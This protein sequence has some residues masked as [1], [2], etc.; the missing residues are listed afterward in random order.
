MAGWMVWLATCGAPAALHFEVFLGYEGVTR[1]A[2]WVPVVVEV[3][4][5]GPSFKG[6]IELVGDPYR[7]SQTTRLAVELPTGTLKRVTLPAFASARFGNDWEARLRDERGK[8]RAEVSPLRPRRAVSWDT[9]TV[10]SLARTAAGLVTF[11]AHWGGPEESRPVA[12]RIQPGI[13]PDNPILLQG[14]DA[15]YLSSEVATG[16]TDE[17]A[18]ALVGWVRGG[19]HLVVGVEQVSD[20]TALPWLRAILPCEPR[21]LR[22]L[23][24]HK[25][26]HRWVQGAPR[27]EG[28]FV[29]LAEDA[30]FERAELPVLAGSVRGGTVVVAVNDVPLVVSAPR[31]A[32]RVTALLFSPEREPARSWRHLPWFWARLLTGSVSAPERSGPA[33][34]FSESADGI[35]GAMIDTRQV[36]KLPVGWLLVLLGVY[37][38]VIGPFDRWWLRRLG[39]PMLTWITFPGYVVG[40]SLLIYFI[41]HQLRSG[42]TES[43]EL[44]IVDVLGN[45]ERADWRGRTFASIYSPQNA[46]FPLESRETFATLRGELAGGRGAGS[47]EGMTVL[48]RGGSF[49]AEVFVP[50]W[51]SRLVVSDW[52]RR[53]RAP[54]EVAVAR[55]GEQWRVTVRNGTDAKL[56]PVHLIVADRVI[57][58]AELEAGQTRVFRVAREGGTTLS[59]FVG[60]HGGMFQSVLQQ[61]RYAFGKTGGGWITDLPPASIA[62]SFLS[63]PGGRRPGTVFTAPAGLDLSE[64]VDR[65]GA[66]LLGWAAQS[67]PAPPLNQVSVRRSA[68]YTLW[69]VPVEIEATQ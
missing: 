34:G 2:C 39:K 68:R 20:V 11:P 3:K 9:L 18:A 17:Q 46:R 64:V 31:R 54:L 59:E 61:R 22:V 28:G 10:A 15:V 52:W 8:V 23:G 37:L 32:G 21:E 33:R 45:G 65:G 35:F 29:E 58:L 27:A 19:G 47:P 13:F 53:G 30:V 60:R 26:L 62:A 50:V 1:E 66:V 5:D 51:T 55:E 49:A 42:E 40:F 43:N 57:P 41:G 69:R 44:H 4:N 14:L 36:K 25:A 63:K 7:A 67:A 6:F 12:V 48:Q 38:V 16:L 56:Q 24:E